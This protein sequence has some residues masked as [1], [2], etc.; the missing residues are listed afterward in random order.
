MAKFIRRFFDE[1]AELTHLGCKLVWF[2]LE[3]YFLCLLYLCFCP[4]PISL[5]GVDTPNIHYWGRVPYLLVPFNSFVSIG[6]LD[7]FKELFWVIGQNFSNLLLLTPLVLGLLALR[8]DWRPWPKV[9]L[10]SFGMSLSIETTQVIIDWLF[11]ANRVFEIDD[12]IFNSLGGLFALWLVSVVKF[13]IK[14]VRNK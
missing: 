8:P 5:K 3:G 14:K 6:K 13:F 2:L 11:N 12:L 9:L 1:E 7:T 10:M 4:Q